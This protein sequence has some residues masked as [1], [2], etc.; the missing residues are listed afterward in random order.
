MPTSVTAA[1]K[2]LRAYL[3]GFTGLRPADGVT[4]RS[5]PVAPEEMTDKQVTL[6]DVVA[7]QARRAYAG[8]DETPTMTCWIAYTAPGADE[9][10]IDAARDG[11]AAL[12]QLVENAL[13]ADQTAGGTIPHPAGTRVIT[14]TLQEMPV[15]WDGTA[16]RRAQYE[17]QVGWTS[18][19]V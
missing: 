15:D 4:I 2:G 14:S 18:H 19:V 3:Q 13:G 11:A 1:K 8:K 9:D 12:L 5:A 17:V 7:P 10:A 16:A 6:G